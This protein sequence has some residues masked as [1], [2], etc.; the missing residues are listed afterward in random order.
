MSDI[1]PE[2]LSDIGFLEKV[3]QAAYYLLENYPNLEGLD[4]LKKQLEEKDKN[5]LV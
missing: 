5:L 1:P 2:I 4:L 3:Q